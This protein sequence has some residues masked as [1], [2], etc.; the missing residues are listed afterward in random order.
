MDSQLIE[1]RGIKHLGQYKPIGSYALVDGM[2]IL[3]AE[4]GVFPTVRSATIRMNVSY[5]ENHSELDNAI[6]IDAYR[7][8]LTFD[9]FVL[10]GQ[11]PIFYFDQGEIGDIVTIPASAPLSASSPDYKQIDYQNISRQMFHSLDENEALPMIS[12]SDLYAKYLLLPNKTRDMIEWYV[13]SL[14][15]PA[16]RQGAFFN[17]NYWQLVHA[18]ILLE[19]LIGLPESCSHSLANITTCKCG[20]KS[21]P[22]HALSRND[23]IKK[24]LS[25]ATNDAKVAEQYVALVINGKKVRDKMGHSPT[26]DRSVTPEFSLEE[27]QIYGTD[28]ATSEYENDSIALQSLIISLNK[29]AR[30][31]L[32]DKAFGTKYFPTL[33][34][35]KSVRVAAASH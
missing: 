29:V 23:W 11:W 6:F 1:R 26:F 24:F 22:H 12:Y 34:S 2:H 30:Y 15:L 10:N 19:Q 31:L 35:L 27:A 17:T 33:P 32:L 4:G 14:S 3:P 13:S 9:A 8:W 16:T 20:R 18:T 7:R 5:I 21:Q 28:R 25:D